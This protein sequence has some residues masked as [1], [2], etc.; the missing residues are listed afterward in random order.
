[1]DPES[2]CIV[3]TKLRKY[4]VDIAAV[5]VTNEVLCSGGHYT[6]ECINNRRKEAILPVFVKNTS[7][8]T[9]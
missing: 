4:T 1:M 2:S 3:Q 9:V 7:R 5:Y 6:S 8:T